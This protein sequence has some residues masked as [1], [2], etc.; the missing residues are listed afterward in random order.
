MVRRTCYGLMVMLIVSTVVVAE[1]TPVEVA[2]HLQ[3]IS[4]TIRS[5]RSEGSGVVVTKL[6]KEDKKINFVWTAGHVVAGLRRVRSVIDPKTGISRQIVFFDD[7]QVIKELVE[8]G[9]RVGELKMDAEVIR[10]SNSTSGEDLALLRIRK[11]NFL[12]ESATFYLEEGILPIGTPLLHVGSLLGQ[13]GANSMTTGIMSQVG[14][15]INNKPYD[16][17]TVAA[18]PGSSGGGVYTEQ[19][20]YMGMLVRGAGETFNLVVPIRRMS[21]WAKTAGV[22]FAI[23]PDTKLPGDEYFSKLPIEDIGHEWQKNYAKQIAED[24]INRQFPFRI[25][26]LPPTRIL[27]PACRDCKL[28]ADLNAAEKKAT[29]DF[30]DN[31][32]EIR[33]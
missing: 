6:D 27:E 21:E 13:M 3:A 7:A 8:D 25:R 14:R 18:F 20:L 1:R 22:D 29:E 4:V 28:S 11:E 5:N 17:T 12:E 26:M 19:G 2:E 24:I 10:Y 30:Y 23:H 9:R 15:V 33:P 16:Q 31:I 32:Y